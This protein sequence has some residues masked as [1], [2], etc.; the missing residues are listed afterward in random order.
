[1]YYPIHAAEQRP[2]LE[3]QFDSPQWAAAKVL[4]LTHWQ[5]RGSS[6]RPLV[7]AKVLYDDR[8]LDLIFRVEDRYVR[9]LVT[10]YQGMVC[11]DSCV[12]FFVEPV[13][14]RGYFNFEVNAGGALHLSFIEDHRPT[15]GGFAR[16]TPVPRELG[17]QVEI[18]HSMPKVVD[19]EIAQA[20]T[21]TVQYH[22]PYAIFEHYL[23]KVKPKPGTRWRANFYKCADH[24][25]HPHWAMWAPVNGSFSFHQPEYFGVVEFK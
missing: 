22:V 25:S 23:G 12:E 7:R 17:E 20:V 21:W 10:K 11:T 19:P 5:Q 15:H 6:H 1:M 2:K 14:S 24:T 16:W 3:G 4:E 13:P 9:S 8:G 18:Y